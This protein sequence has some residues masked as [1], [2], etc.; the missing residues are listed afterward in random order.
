MKYGEARK[1]F[2]D[3]WGTLGSS[4]GISRTEAQI[5]ALL[6]VSPKALTTDDIMGELGISRGNVSMGLKSLQDWGIVFKEFEPG[7]RKKFYRTEKDVLKLATQVAK[8][9]RR[10]E[11]E[12]IIDMLNE[13]GD[14]KDTSVAKEQLQELNKMTSALSDFA[15]QS[16]RV[17]GQF[18]KS[19]KGWFFKTMM[20]LFK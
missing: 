11:I 7:E 16:D 4:W 6:M 2:I 5:H 15:N 8:E 10:R 13:V 19:E 18:I 12:P 14:V 3:A 1:R 17:L 9:R 20:K